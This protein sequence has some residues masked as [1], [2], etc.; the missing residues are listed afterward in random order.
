MTEVQEQGYQRTTIEAGGDGT[1]P[2]GEDDLTG[3]GI[4]GAIMDG[5][6]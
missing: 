4:K 5:V 1:G 3:M 6:D 2:V